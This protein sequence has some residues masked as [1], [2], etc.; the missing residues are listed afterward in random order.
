MLQIVEKDCNTHNT[1]IIAICN[2]K[3][4]VAKT[5]TAVN[6]GI[7]LAREGKH[8]LLVD[9]DAQASLTVSLGYQQPDQLDYTITTAMAAT[10]EEKEVSLQ[11]MIL[12]HSEG[13]DLLPS[14]IE[15]S[16]ME[17]TLVNTIGRETILRECLKPIRAQYDYILLDCMPS[18]WRPQTEPSFPF[19]HNTCH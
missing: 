4:G 10:I 11:E 3:G 17:V 6:L 13:I 15:L 1:K 9:L 12:P 19:R 18:F 7:G 8:V 16:A 2:Q 5:V 14:N